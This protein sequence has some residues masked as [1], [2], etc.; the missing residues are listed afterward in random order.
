MKA[1]GTGGLVRPRQCNADEDKLLEGSAVRGGSS[2][3]G[4]NGGDG[5]EGKVEENDDPE[6]RQF[7]E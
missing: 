4:L 3:S 2:S 6:A 7:D 5:E 1:I